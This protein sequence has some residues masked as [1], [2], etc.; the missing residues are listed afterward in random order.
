[1]LVAARAGVFCPDGEAATVCAAVVDGANAA[2][3]AVAVTDTSIFVKRFSFA[4]EKI[5]GL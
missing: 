2:I 5:C 1:V 4:I 3:T